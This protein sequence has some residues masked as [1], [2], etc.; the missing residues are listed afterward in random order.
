MDSHEFTY[1]GPARLTSALAQELDERGVAVDYE[2]PMEYKDAALALSI[3]S[4]VFSA[5]GPLTNI[6]GGVRAFT[7]RWPGTRVEG[8]PGGGSTIEERLGR[9]EKLRAD[10]VITEQEYAE[11]RTRILGEL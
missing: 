5:T 6:V 9:L 3:A 11:Q 10:A 4:V 2:P 7:A 1:V 8:L